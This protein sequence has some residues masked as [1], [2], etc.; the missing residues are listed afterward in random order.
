MI[1]DLSWGCKKNLSNCVVCVAEE[2]SRSR[3]ERKKENKQSTK[4]ERQKKKGQTKRKK[5]TQADR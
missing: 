5:K 2:T 3:K 1:T 4:I